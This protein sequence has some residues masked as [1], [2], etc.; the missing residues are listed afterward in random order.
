MAAS[1]KVFG[2]G[3][4]V[5]MAAAKSSAAATAAH[6]AAATAAAANV[7]PRGLMKPLRVSPA[8]GAF[9]GVSEASRS[10]VVKKVW[11]HIKLNNLQGYFGGHGGRRVRGNE[12]LKLGS[13]TVPEDK[14][15][16]GG[17]ALPGPGVSDEGFNPQNKK[18]IICDEKLKTIFD[19][20]D[21]VGFLEIA[22]LLKPH[23]VV[24][25]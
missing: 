19:G 2:R 4:R 8:L 18:E 11:Q 9:L 21:K 14:L 10:D 23:F 1:S 5:L 16:L 24:S 3:C 6:T 17:G 22:K 12:R 20:K 15:L 25:K 13:V 7:A